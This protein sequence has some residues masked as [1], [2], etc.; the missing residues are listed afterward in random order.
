[1]F[2]HR[3]CSNGKIKTII[4]L[5]GSF[6]IKMMEVLV[7]IL[8]RTPKTPGVPNSLS[9][10]LYILAQCAKR[11]HDNNSKRY[12]EHPHHFYRG[13]PSRV[14]NYLSLILITSLG[15][16][17]NA[18]LSHRSSYVTMDCMKRS[19]KKTKHPRFKNELQMYHFML[20]LCENK[21]KLTK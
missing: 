8:K 4:N 18:G 6:R 20:F 21:K 19:E 2:Y 9:V 3:A 10:C 16:D 14:I 11:Y 5:G 12:D 13:F 7:K 1:M 15:S 17:S